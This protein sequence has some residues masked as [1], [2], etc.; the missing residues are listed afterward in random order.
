MSRQKTHPVKLPENHE[1][2]EDF[3]MLSVLIK[4]VSGEC[5]LQ[6][7][8][9]FYREHAIGERG[10]MPEDITG[11][12][13]DGV[14]SAPAQEC[15][16]LFQG[17]EPTLAGLPFF[18]RFVA[19]T[20]EKNHAGVPV[21]Y[22]MQTNGTLVDDAW[23]AFFRKNGF[24]VGVS[25]DGTRDIHDRY[26]KNPDGRGSF[27]DA[28][29][30]IQLLHAHGVESSV[31]ITITDDL[32]YNAAKIWENCQQ[33]GWDNL[34]IIPCLPNSGMQQALSDEAYGLFLCELF[35]RWYDGV[36]RGRY[37][38][39]RLFENYVGLLAGGKYELCGLTG[40]CDA[41][42]VVERDGSCYPC[43]FFVSPEWKLGS[44]E[45][46]SIE[47]LREKSLQLFIKNT[48][49]VTPATCIDCQYK[50]ICGGGCRRYR[51][52]AGEYAFCVST[53]LFF[54][55]CFTRLL[56][57]ADQERIASGKIPLVSGNE[58]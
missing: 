50:R 7:E 28:N 20:K 52:Q 29:R 27:D 33:Y 58:R 46:D 11:A 56:L 17:G 1:K 22:S 49:G 44:V 45:T 13:L 12:L 9:C 51:N 39:V 31:L 15:A 35:D 8:Y 57:L 5:N 34:H 38:C 2:V 40:H 30:A 6:C 37:I 47:S 53:R 21:S 36:L 41:T 43:D 55:K 42:L 26:R 19:L 18:E 4:P 23:A 48:A 54:E 14:F 3:D 10:V 32:A 16:F 25:L 24:L